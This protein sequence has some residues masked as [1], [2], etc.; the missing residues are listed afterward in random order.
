MRSHAQL[1]WSC[2]TLRDPMDCNPPSSLSMGFCRQEYWSGLPCP[3]PGDPPNR[4]VK[5]ES[6]ALQADSL[7]IEPPGKPYC[8]LN[9][10]LVHRHILESFDSLEF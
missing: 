2:L 6:P 10:L 3:P 5:P 7:P 8:H 4:R 9:S 1:L